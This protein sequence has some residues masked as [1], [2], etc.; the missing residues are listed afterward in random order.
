MID[1]DTRVLKMTPE[2]IAAIDGELA[3]VAT[4]QEQGRS[5]AVHY[6]TEGQL[7]TLDVYAR[8]ARDA[9]VNN[10]SD[11][12]ALHELRKCAAIAIRALLTEGCPQRK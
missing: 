1:M 11:S 5:D 7:L 8:R 10:P 3:Y 2:V 9:W 6:G 12:E 4:L